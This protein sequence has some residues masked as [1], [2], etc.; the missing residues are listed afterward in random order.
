VIVFLIF[1]KNRRLKDQEN[2]HKRQLIL[3]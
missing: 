3:D 2:N 1:G